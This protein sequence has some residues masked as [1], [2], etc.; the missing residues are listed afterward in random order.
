MPKLLTRPVFRQVICKE[1]I[2]SIHDILTSTGFFYREEIEIG[3]D[4]ALDR[5]KYGTESGYSFLFADV[6]GRVAG[7]TCFGEIPCTFGSFD[8][9]WIAVHPDFQRK[10]IG[11]FLLYETEEIASKM[12]CRRIYIETSARD[13]YVPTQKFYKRCGYKKE[14]FLKDYYTPGDG[15]IVYVK[16]LQISPE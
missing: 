10:G 3:V 15:K 2:V 4:L 5:L 6:S 8:L 9:Y 13:L 11:E 1:D 14:A 7:Y 12:G 16:A